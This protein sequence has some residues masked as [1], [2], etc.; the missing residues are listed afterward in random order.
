MV[1]AVVGLAIERAVHEVEGVRSKP[2]NE[3]ARRRRSTTP[4]LVAAALVLTAWANLAVTRRLNFDEALALRSGYWAF[5]DVPSSPPF[6]MPFVL[7]VGS[8]GRLVNDPG[9][10]F[11]LARLIS[12]G[13]VTAS[14]ALLVRSRGLLAGAVFALLCLTQSEFVAHGFEFR[15]DAAILSGLML[16]ALCLERGSTRAFLA[17][18]VLVAWLAAHHLKGLY[19]AASLGALGVLAAVTS[20]SEVSV[21]LLRL[22]GG[23]LGA[24]ALW[25]ALTAALGGL[26][27]LSSTYSFFYRVS[28][29]E[30][31]YARPGVVLAPSLSWNPAWWAAVLASL[32]LVVGSVVRQP[33]AKLTR[34]RRIWP[35]LIACVGLAF[36]ALH[37]RPWQYMLAVPVPFLSLVIVDAAPIARRSLSTVRAR[38]LAAVAAAL[39][40]VALQ[41]LGDSQPWEPFEHAASAPRASEVATLRLT[42]SLVA[43][44]DRVLDPSGLVYFTP[45]CSAEW[46]TDS[47][48]YRLA[49]RD[50][51]MTRLASEL[52]SCRFLLRTNRIRMLPEQARTRAETD[53][54]TMPGGG[55]LCV[56][57]DAGP[58]PHIAP[59]RQLPHEALESYWFI[60]RSMSE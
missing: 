7:M 20:K 51:W 16:G 25:L 15:Y 42:K 27:D 22:A 58:V 8:L 4:A 52:D 39:A 43:P 38:A 49:Q 32:V 55:G 57:R 33:L 9:T 56:R 12:L 36:V 59:A 17:L 53:F 46:Y 18:G 14:G 45:S 35:V 2:G 5:G 41:L 19:F 44:S 34:D 50:E 54:V 24:A 37:P 3:V 21:K 31:P 10:V 1:P 28:R 30:V 23:F 26:H 29:V 60:P 48:F 11:V 6:W 13:L 40:V 47:L